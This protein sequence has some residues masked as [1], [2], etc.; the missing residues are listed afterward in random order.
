MTKSQTSQ[1]WP[2][3]LTSAID[4]ELAL[5]TLLLGLTELA[6]QGGSVDNINVADNPGTFPYGKPSD[7]K[8]QLAVYR[9]IT[10]MRMSYWLV[11]DRYPMIAGEWLE[12]DSSRGSWYEE[13]RSSAAERLRIAVIAI[14]RLASEQAVLLKKASTDVYRRDAERLV[15][16]QLAAA[17]HM[18]ELNERVR[19][20]LPVSI[21]VTQ[22]RYAHYREKLRTWQSEVAALLKQCRGIKFRHEGISHT[23][24]QLLRQAS[25]YLPE[26]DREVRGGVRQDFSINYRTKPILFMG[27]RKT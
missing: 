24:N 18:L 13:K 1:G 9:L 22:F 19:T 25:F 3:V 17:V 7:I 20:A 21:E 16:E 10:Q 27:K 11:L 14:I 12:Q 8:A 4:E 15:A 6:S 23:Y 26:I 5:S 2:D